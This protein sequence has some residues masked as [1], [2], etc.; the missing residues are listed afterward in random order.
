MALLANKCSRRPPMIGRELR[1]ASTKEWP[2]FP[3]GYRD[4]LTFD[5]L[6]GST[7]IAAAGVVA[8]WREI[9][10]VARQAG[11]DTHRALR[12][13]RGI[14]CRRVVGYTIQNSKI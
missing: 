11:G 8:Y 9:P 4:W 3:R 10:S 6:T 7:F 14:G 12:S 2:E 13:A 1:K 5:T